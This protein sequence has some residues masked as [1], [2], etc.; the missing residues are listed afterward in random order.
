MAYK[1]AFKPAKSKKASVHERNGTKCASLAVLPQILLRKG[2]SSQFVR[3]SIVRVM[4]Q[5]NQRL[6]GP[7][8]DTGNAQAMLD[9]PPYRFLISCVSCERGGE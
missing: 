6:R 3:L 5:S 8:G 7:I 2:F 4:S 9:I 1:C